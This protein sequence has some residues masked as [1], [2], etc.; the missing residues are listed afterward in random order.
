MRVMVEEDGPTTPPKRPM[1]EE[2]GPPRK[3][4]H[5]ATKKFLIS[6]GYFDR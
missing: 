6:T 2:D 1:E 4:M 3:R 5:P